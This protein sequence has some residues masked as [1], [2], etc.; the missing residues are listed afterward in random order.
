[1]V[2]WKFKK[3][4]TNKVYSLPAGSY[5]IGDICYVLDDKIYH[6]IFGAS[7]Y[8]SGLYTSSLGQFLV[9]N[10]YAG[11]GSYPGTDGFTYAVDAGIIGIVSKSLVTTETNL[12]KI[13]NFPTGVEVTMDDGVFTFESEETSFQINTR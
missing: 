8:S 5:Y 1:M 7:G 2:V 9:S 12:G 11:D 10:T 4:D 13:Y 3:I 6:N